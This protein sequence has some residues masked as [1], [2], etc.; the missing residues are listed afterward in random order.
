VTSNCIGVSFCFSSAAGGFWK[1]LIAEL[2][3][4]GGTA[5]GVFVEVCDDAR[6]QPAKATAAR[7]AATLG[8]PKGFTRFMQD[9]S[10]RGAVGQRLRNP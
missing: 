4:G 9:N 7:A 3:N 10:T 1:V 8:Q 2:V 5:A 6:V